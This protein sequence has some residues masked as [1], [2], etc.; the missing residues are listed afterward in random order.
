MIY[1]FKKAGSNL[2]ADSCPA[3]SL[4]SSYCFL[5]WCSFLFLLL[6]F[7][8]GMYTD[9][10]A[11]FSAGVSLILCCVANRRVPDWTSPVVRSLSLIIYSVCGAHGPRKCW[12]PHA[13]IK[14]I[15]PNKEKKNKNSQPPKQQPKK[16][17]KN[18]KKIL[19]NRANGKIRKHTS[20]ALLRTDSTSPL[21]EKGKNK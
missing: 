21:P 6:F 5:L 2:Y 10:R 18:E 17:K 20:N 13:S 19:S 7:G 12:L 16:Y 8:S 11:R 15:V 9:A 3:L 1:I 14:M 4:S